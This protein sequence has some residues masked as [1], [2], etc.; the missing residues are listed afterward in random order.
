MFKRKTHV[1]LSSL[2]KLVISG[3]VSRLSQQI[4]FFQSLFGNFLSDT[5]LNAFFRVANKISIAIFLI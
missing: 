5:T 4:P 2:P 3:N 1:I